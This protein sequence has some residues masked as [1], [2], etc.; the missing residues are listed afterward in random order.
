VRALFHDTVD[1]TNEVGK[2][3]LQ[4]GRITETT[5]VIAREQT[6]GK[7]THGRCW[8]S[9]RDAGIYMSVV[10]VAERGP[11]PA[12]NL[13]SLSAGIACVEGLYD[14]VGLTVGI[15]PIN[16]LWIS[17]CKLG[18]VLVETIV[19]DH[20]PTA[21]ITGVGINVRRVERSLPPGSTPAICLEDLISP[22]PFAWFDAKGLAEKL[23]EGIDRW[24]RMV[25][26]GQVSLVQETW[27]RLLVPSIGQATSPSRPCE[28]SPSP[29]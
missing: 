5:W 19:Q 14:A 27:N 3:L 29:R 18:G 17:E 28:T 13:Y 10:H 25:M 12:S 9:P 24:H 8:L 22:E 1:S 4:G 26:D 6:A 7:G 16:D 21:I 23:A 20:A 2:R 11:I 15:K